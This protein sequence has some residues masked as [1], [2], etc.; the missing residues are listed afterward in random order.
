MAIVRGNEFQLLDYTGEINKIPRLWNL[1]DSLGIFD[2]EGVQTDFVNV[3]ITQ[4][5]TLPIGDQRRGGERN[6]NAA[7]QTTPFTLHMPFF[8]LD[9][10]IRPSD[11][12]N[13][14]QIGT[15]QDPARVAALRLKIMEQLR[16]K[17][18]A[19][20]E[21]ALANALQ[22]LSYAPNGTTTA[23]NYYTTFGQTQVSVDFDF[24]NATANPMAKAEIARASIVDNAQDGAGAYTVTAICGPTWFQKLID[25]PMV[26]EA[27]TFF[28][29]TQDPLRS[30]NAMGS[31]D[32]IYRDFI[33]GDVHYI[34]YRGSFAGTALIPADQA[35]MFPAGIADMFKVFHGPADHLDYVNSVGQELYMFEY[36]EQSGR[37]MHIESETAMIA[38]NYRPELVIKLTS[39]T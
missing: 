15:A 1:L 38:V 16:R 9:D 2:T 29:S 3:D 13:L 27:Y 34:E 8:P 5:K 28:T 30:R 33:Y 17:Q 32:G 11:L 25:H 26:R 10:S 18:G 35:F 6:F 31:R 7:A 36:R 4:D 23:Y 20:R 24:G 37:R 12:Q 39:S 19:T 14:R 22:G 21:K